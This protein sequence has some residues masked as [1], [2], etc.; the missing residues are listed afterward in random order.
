M[1]HLANLFCQT[2]KPPTPS[3]ESILAIVSVFFSAKCSNGFSN[4]QHTILGVDFGSKKIG[5]ALSDRT[6]LIASPFRVLTVKDTS[7]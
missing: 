4:Y 2:F 5:L 6:G 1:S 7:V 3:R